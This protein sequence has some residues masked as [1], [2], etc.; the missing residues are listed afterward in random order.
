MGIGVGNINKKQYENLMEDYH[1]TVETPKNK[2]T[3]GKVAIYTGIASSIGAG[4][5]ISLKIWSKKGKR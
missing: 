4:L 3:T 5:L 1:K 2:T